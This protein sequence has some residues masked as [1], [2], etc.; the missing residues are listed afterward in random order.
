MTSIERAMET[1]NRLDG[2]PPIQRIDTI[3]KALRE[4]ASDDQIIH[5]SDGYKKPAASDRQPSKPKKS[6]RK[7]NS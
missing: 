1:F 5:S 7:V 2:L 6:K 4:V 3:N